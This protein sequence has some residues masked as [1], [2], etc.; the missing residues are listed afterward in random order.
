MA[1][2]SLR[3][4][5]DCSAGTTILYHL[6]ICRRP[7]SSSGMTAGRQELLGD[8]HRRRFRLGHRT[9]PR[10]YGPDGAAGGLSQST[11]QQVDH[12]TTGAGRRPGLG[13]RLFAMSDEALAGYLQFWQGF[14]LSDNQRA[15]VWRLGDFEYPSFFLSNGIFVRI[16]RCGF[17]LY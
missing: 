7:H 17:E 10:D 6:R 15:D 13:A 3:H 16:I 14:F 8:G 12:A 9:I 5:R 4:R 11:Q 2:N 1:D